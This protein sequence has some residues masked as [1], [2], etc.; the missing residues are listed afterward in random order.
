MGLSPLR[1][2]GRA[3]PAR[4]VPRRVLV[5]QG[6]L[7]ILVGRVH[8]HPPKGQGSRA[9][10]GCLAAVRMEKWYQELSPS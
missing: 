4:H 7:G 9:H 5:G 1:P 8:P 3:S 6:V 2:A 10:P